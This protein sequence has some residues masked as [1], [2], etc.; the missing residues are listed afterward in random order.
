MAQGG[1][2]DGQLTAKTTNHYFIDSLRFL[3]CFFC[4]WV[5]VL[6]YFALE[7]AITEKTTTGTVRQH[8]PQNPISPILWQSLHIFS[9]EQVFV[10]LIF[11]PQTA[12]YYSSILC[13]FSAGLFSRF[14]F[15]PQTAKPYFVVSPLCICKTVKPLWEPQSW[16]ALP[17]L[18]VHYSVSNMF[19]LALVLSSWIIAG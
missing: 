2:T 10:R 6:V 7:H 17:D 13:I 19:L 5:F 14:I 16:S 11:C 12:K 8:K 9:L 15:R 18:L 1:L 3:W 4:I